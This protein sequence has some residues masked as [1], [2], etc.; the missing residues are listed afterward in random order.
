ML[1]RHGYTSQEADIVIE[2]VADNKYSHEE[3]LKIID[4]RGISKFC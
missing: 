4:E 3:F 2:L 1:I